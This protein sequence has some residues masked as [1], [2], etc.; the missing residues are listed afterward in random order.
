VSAA[1]LPAPQLPEIN[2]DPF[3]FCT[4]A[5]SKLQE[6]L[7]I[8]VGIVFEVFVLSVLFF[9]AKRP[10]HGRHPG[11]PSLFDAILRDATQ[12]FI[13]LT[14]CNITTDAF[15]IF[16]PESISGLP[17]LASTV[18]IPLMAS[19]LMLSLKKAAAEPVR[20]CT[21]SS[22]GDP[23]LS[24]IS[25]SVRFSSRVPGTV[26]GTPVSASF[27]DE[28]VELGYVSRVPRRDGHGS[29]VDIPPASCSASD[30]FL[31]ARAFSERTL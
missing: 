6:L 14:L 26:P 2:L 22:M 28:G 1:V 19:R 7:F 11:I 12:Y 13:L 5:Q 24:A 31:V 20:V 4:V 27:F 30:D 10:R 23:R 16:A 21:V 3:K 29:Q 8:N 25:R 17:G 18:L 15:V 9:A